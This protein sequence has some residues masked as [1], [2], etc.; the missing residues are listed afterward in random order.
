M[1]ADHRKTTAAPESCCDNT[2][3]IHIKSK[4][5]QWIH[6]NSVLQD[7]AGPLLPA[8]TWFVVPRP[9]VSRTSHLAASSPAVSRTSH[10]AASSPAA[11]ASWDFPKW[12]I[13]GTS[14]PSLYGPDLALLNAEIFGPRPAFR[15]IVLYSCFSSDRGRWW[16]IACGD[17]L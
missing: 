13:T 3:N 1:Y 7:G 5:R 17:R 4:K 10:L 14:N 6:L 12:H 8:C 11:V 2:I 15:T 9:V 16:R